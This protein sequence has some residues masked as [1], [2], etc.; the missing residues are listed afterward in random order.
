MSSGI[1][2]II[3]PSGKRYIGSAVNFKNRWQEHI[4]QLRKG[5]HHSPAL[6]RAFVKYGEVAFQFSILEECAREQLLSF[7]QKHIDAW[8]FDQ[9]YNICPSA[10]SALGVKRSAATRAR[11][12]ASKKG[13]PGWA[14]TAES[15]KRVADANRK[16]TLSE[17]TRAKIAASR[18][19]KS[20]TEAQRIGL[21]ASRRTSGY[22]GVSYDKAQKKW[23]AYAQVEGRRK[24]FGSF[25]TAELANAY[26][27]YCLATLGVA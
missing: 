25:A 12:S 1:Y 26:R 6:Q 24:Y 20:L 15:R 23:T 2:A 21:G 9:L 5:I 14:H 10:G 18:S 16:R 4:R 13:Q 22:N 17:A 19:G 7:E 8:P 3:S 27:L 11:I